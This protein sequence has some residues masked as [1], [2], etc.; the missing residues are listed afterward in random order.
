MGKTKTKTPKVKFTCFTE[1]TA[2]KYPIIPSGKNHLKWMKRAIQY[3]KSIPTNGLK[4]TKCP[5]I[6]SIINEGWILRSSMHVKILTKGDGK[7]FWWDTSEDQIQTEAG[8]AFCGHYVH[9]HNPEQLTQFH[10]KTPNTLETIIKIQTPWFVEIPKGY[11]LLMMPLPYSDD[12]RFTAAAGILRG[13]QPLNVQ[14]Y[15][16]CLN[17]EEV[18]PAGTPLNQMVLIKDESIGYEVNYEPNPTQYIKEKFDKKI[19]KPLDFH[20]EKK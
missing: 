18:I 9:F 14:L 15:W 10:E 7:N 12:K 3:Y 8:K 17:S 11:S 2:K 1:E 19:I 20:K 6:A 16:H 5:G 13:N 4:I